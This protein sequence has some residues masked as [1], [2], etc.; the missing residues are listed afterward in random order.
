MSYFNGL[1]VIVWM[2][3]G[4]QNLAVG[5]CPENEQEKKC[6][7]KIYPQNL[8]ITLSLICRNLS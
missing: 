2:D 4:I 3:S 1:I 7:R 5:D 8:W 6:V